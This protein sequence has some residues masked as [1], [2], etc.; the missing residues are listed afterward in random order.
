MTKRRVLSFY[1][2]HDVMM[3]SIA[4]SVPD[5]QF[6]LA[7]IRELDYPAPLLLA[8]NIT[9]LNETW[10]EVDES[11]YDLV[12]FWWQIYQV[13]GARR[14]TLPRIA[15]VLNTGDPIIPGCDGVV[16]NTWLTQERSSTPGTVIPFCLS[17]SVL[18]DWTGEDPRA[19]F[20]NRKSFYDRAGSGWNVP[21]WE[22]FVKN[23]P[24]YVPDTFQS[25][26]EYL[27]QRKK[28]RCYVEM[29]NR[30]NTCAFF[31]AL[32]MGQPTIVP[33]QRDYN[34]VIKSGQ[35]GFVY[36]NTNEAVVM[37]RDL[38]WDLSLARKIG[39]AGARTAQ[40]LA[41]DDLR[42]GLWES[43]FRVAVET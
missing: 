20:C 41:G 37:A 4:G 40:E 29:S 1:P 2:T 13:V 23:V 33:D 22:S 8:K 24:F 6:D 10:K 27:A 3:N 26:K 42:N 35:N 11:R 25:W 31:E 9:L 16:Y 19:Y 7:K 15:L 30:V 12:I 28:M 21:L 38:I 34:L 32:M 39:E 17:R 5:V 43:M 36:R 18:G 14:W